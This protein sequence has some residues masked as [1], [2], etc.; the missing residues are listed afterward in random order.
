MKEHLLEGQ[1]A[2]EFLAEEHHASDPEENDVVSGF[3]KGI[4]EECLHVVRVVG[5]AHNGE[6]E[7]AGAEPGVEHVFVL[8][9]YNFGWVDLELG[10]R[11]G[12]SL[13]FGPADNPVGVVIGLVLGNRN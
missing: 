11:L 12:Q 10:G 3:E 4:G 7:E 5:P 13:F 8:G 1:F 6:G 9:E 2:E